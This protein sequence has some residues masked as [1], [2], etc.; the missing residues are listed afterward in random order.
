LD[1][2]HALAL[3]GRYR[4]A[5]PLMLD[6]YHALGKK[7]DYWAEKERRAALGRLVELYRM[8]RRPDEA[9]KHRR[10]VAP[11]TRRPGGQTL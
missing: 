9:A 3:Q 7:S 5:E 11:W 4:E 10:L 8:E 6:A 2:G 1:L